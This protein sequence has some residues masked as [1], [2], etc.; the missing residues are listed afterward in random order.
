LPGSLPAF[1]PPSEFKPSWA[2]S[3]LNRK[4]TPTS[5]SPCSAMPFG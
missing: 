2:A 1:F 5:Y 4:K 3:L